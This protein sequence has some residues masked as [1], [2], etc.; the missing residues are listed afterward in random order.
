MAR[1]LNQ[2]ADQEPKDAEIPLFKVK[3][4]FGNPAGIENPWKDGLF[5]YCW[6]DPACIFFATSFYELL[7]QHCQ[8]GILED[9]FDADLNAR[10]VRE[11]KL[12]IDAAEMDSFVDGADSEG[13]DG[14]EFIS[15]RNSLLRF[16]REIKFIGHVPIA[17]KRVLESLDLMQEPRQDLADRLALAR[18]IFPRELVGP[19]LAGIGLGIEEDDW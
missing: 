8:W 2:G 13:P 4:Q 12:L 10:L 18:Q 15:M 5:D 7:V 6:G 11:R 1:K 17:T 16:M 14:M 9:V 3:C 19:Y